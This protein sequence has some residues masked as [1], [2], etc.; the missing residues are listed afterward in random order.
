MIFHTNW[1]VGIISLNIHN[2]LDQKFFIPLQTK[3]LQLKKYTGLQPRC[4]ET[5]CEMAVAC[6]NTKSS[7]INFSLFVPSV[8]FSY[9]C[10]LMQ[11]HCITF[12]YLQHGAPQFVILNI[13]ALDSTKADF[14]SF[15]R[16]SSYNTQLSLNTQTSS[17]PDLTFLFQSTLLMSLERHW[18]AR[19][20]GGSYRNAASR[21]SDLR[22]EVC[23]DMQ[24]A[25][26]Q[27]S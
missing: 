21:G 11:H 22:A 16:M 1:P 3:G 26:P 24:A 25:G 5:A 18:S 9:Y 20:E 23:Q 8:L 10:I 17:S 6:R 12:V 7:R 27:I 14:L 2:G 15:A 4:C 19:K 13:L